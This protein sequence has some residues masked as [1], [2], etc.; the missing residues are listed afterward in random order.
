MNESLNTYEWTELSVVQSGNDLVCLL[1]SYHRLSDL[2]HTAGIL[3]RFKTLKLSLGIWIVSCSCTWVKWKFKTQISTSC[4]FS[5]H[6]RPSKPR[7]LS[8]ETG[9]AERERELIL[10]SRFTLHYVMLPG[11]SPRG[12]EDLFAGGGTDRLPVASRDKCSRRLSSGNFPM[13]FEMLTIRQRSLRYP[14]SG[15]WDLEWIL[16]VFQLFVQPVCPLW[17]F[18]FILRQSI[19]RNHSEWLESSHCLLGWHSRDQWKLPYRHVGKTWTQI[20]WQIEFFSSKRMLLPTFIYLS[21]GGI[22]I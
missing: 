15:F 2:H 21:R 5:F 17:G 16:T 3:G 20:K 10:S 8:L 7:F 12:T 13:T 9:G 19:V 4:P 6:P 11:A 1:L 22:K 14:G 18:V